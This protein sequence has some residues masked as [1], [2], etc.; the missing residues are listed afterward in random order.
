MARTIYKT[1]FGEFAVRRDC[2]YGR[3]IYKATRVFTLH[4]RRVEI[5]GYFAIGHRDPKAMDRELLATLYTG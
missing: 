1:R 3:T 2:V 5:G 4:G